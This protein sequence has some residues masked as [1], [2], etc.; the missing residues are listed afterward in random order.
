MARPELLPKRLFKKHF[1]LEEKTRGL[2]EQETLAP[3]ASAA[4]TQTALYNL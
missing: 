1:L 2:T 3:I 4:I